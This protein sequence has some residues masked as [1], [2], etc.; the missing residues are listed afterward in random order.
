M[1]TCLPKGMLVFTCRYPFT[2]F[3]LPCFPLLILLH[4]LSP[5]SPFCILTV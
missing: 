5:F 4:E 1:P 3:P 2:A